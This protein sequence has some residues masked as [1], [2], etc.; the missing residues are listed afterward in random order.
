MLEILESANWGGSLFLAT[1]A[2]AF[3]AAIIFLSRITIY[4]RRRDPSSWYDV[5]LLATI[6]II[7]LVGAILLFPEVH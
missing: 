3:C 1:I 2:T 4:K 6:F 5:A 7:W